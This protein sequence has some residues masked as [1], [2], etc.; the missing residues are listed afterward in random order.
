MD[1]KFL[2]I[3]TL[4]IALPLALA[5]CVARDS[6]VV[7]HDDLSH[8]QN[9]LAETDYADSQMPPQA[10]LPGTPAPV[11]MRGDAE[12]TYWNLSLD[13]AIR[14]GLGSTTV[15]ADLGGTILQAPQ[16]LETLQNPSIVETDPRF[17]VQAALSAFDAELVANAFFEKNH[18]QYNN[19]FAV[20]TTERQPFMQDRHD[21]ETALRKRGATGTEYILRQTWDYDGNNANGNIFRSSWNTAVEAEFRHPLMQGGGID[22]NRIAGPNGT[23]GN[24]NGVVIARIN[25]DISLTEL[26]VGLRN[27]V[28][29]VENAYW[30]L[31]YAYR[32][33]DVKKRARDYSHDFLKK[34][35]ALGGLP[36]GEADRVA[37]AREQYLRFEADVE[38]ALTG[39]LVQGTQADNDTT[40]GTFRANG[41]VY[42]AERRLRLLLGLPLNGD[43]LLRPAQD[44]SLAKV[45]F[46]WDSVVGECLI[47][48]AELRRQRLVVQRREMELIAN[49]NFL[50]PRLDAVGT[51][52]WRGFGHDLLNAN[53]GSAGRFDNAY[54]NLTSGDFQEWRLG[55]EFAVPLGFRQAHSAIRNAEL[56]LARDQ[57]ILDRQERQVLHDLSNAVSEMERAYQVAQINFDRRNAAIERLEAL[58]VL[59]TEGVLRGGQ[60]AQFVNDMLDAQ[61]RLAAADS[62]FFRALTEYALAVKN[63]H[64]EKGTWKSFHEV[65]LAEDLS[66]PSAAP[67]MVPAHPW[68]PEMHIPAEVEVPE[69]PEPSPATPPPATPEAPLPYTPNTAFVPPPRLGLPVA[70]P[71]YRPPQGV[72]PPPALPGAFGPST[73]AGAAPRVV[74]PP[75]AL[76]A[77]GP[78]I[79]PAPPPISL[80][81]PQTMAMP[82]AYRVPPSGTAPG[83]TP[84]SDQPRR[85]LVTDDFDGLD[86]TPPAELF[87]SGGR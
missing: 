34:L 51:Y 12:L 10:V 53:G 30:D 17:G 39:R 32:D 5:G 40:G 68:Q 57:A 29:N 37:Q 77:T 60:W 56:A 86:L 20:G 14:V 42:V 28:S 80:P 69:L 46:D 75:P 81:R 27:Y 25:T 59:E 55:V 48:R 64:V 3:W 52:R 31:Y 16:S 67:A 79:L 72:D 63:V 78:L 76:P 7:F 82:T 83:G 49:R 9:I 26:E 21:Y 65:F 18:R 22:F 2:S 70:A 38:N 62:D 15:L 13:E 43:Q 85:I 23:P 33:L 11:A 24:L 45:M 36:R 58:K 74:P 35:E 84:M 50:M 87:D 47:R 6:A 8:Y 61:Q 1:C 44:P 19:D 4:A 41:G 66:C 54:G 73:P 71:D